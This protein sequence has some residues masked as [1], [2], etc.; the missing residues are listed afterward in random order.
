MA[1]GAGSTDHKHEMLV[2]SCLKNG[3]HDGS[4]AVDLPIF[5]VV[6]GIGDVVDEDEVNSVKPYFTSAVSLWESLA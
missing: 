6:I 3:G 2:K 5:A 1:V 4:K